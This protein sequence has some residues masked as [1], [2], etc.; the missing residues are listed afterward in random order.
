M[1]DRE[2]EM[3]CVDFFVM[4]CGLEFSAGKYSADRTARVCT[5]LGLD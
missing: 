2:R 5:G 4:I 1:T 3:V